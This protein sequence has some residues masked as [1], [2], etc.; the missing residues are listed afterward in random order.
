M[1]FFYG[2]LFLLTEPKFHSLLTLSRNNSSSKSHTPNK[3]HIFGNARTW[4]FTWSYPGYLFLWANFE[5]WTSHEKLLRSKLLGSLRS[6]RSLRSLIFY[7]LAV[8]KKHVSNIVANKLKKYMC[9]I[10]L[11]TNVCQHIREKKSDFKNI[12]FW[13]SLSS[14]HWV[15]KAEVISFSEKSSTFLAT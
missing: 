5:E 8:G 10:Y 7:K 1:V 14:V 9:W 3:F 11:Q 12:C 15:W 13:H 4:G 6:L 2:S